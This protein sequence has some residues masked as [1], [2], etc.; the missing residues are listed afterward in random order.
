ME[1]IVM[2]DL[3]MPVSLDPR[4]APGQ[5]DAATMLPQPD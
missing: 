2:D 4:G 1:G 5:G 3:P